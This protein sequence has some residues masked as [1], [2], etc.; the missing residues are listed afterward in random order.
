MPETGGYMVAAYVVAGVLYGGYAVWLL[1]KGR[2][3]GR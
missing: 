1:L 2:S 3:K